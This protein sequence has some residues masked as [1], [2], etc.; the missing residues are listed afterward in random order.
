MTRQEKLYEFFDTLGMPFWC[1]AQVCACM[2]CVNG[3]HRTMWTEKYPEEPLITKEEVDQYRAEH[4]PKDI[5][6]PVYFSRLK[7][8]K[9][10]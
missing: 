9:H 4:L 6:T 2:G 5:G 10:D 8:Y 3:S 7:N 1:D